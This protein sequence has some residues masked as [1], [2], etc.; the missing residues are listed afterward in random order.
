MNQRDIR[1][2]DIGMLRTFDALMREQNVS[3]AAARL[4]LSQP[5]VSASLNRLREVFGD[6]L[7]TRTSHG[8]VPTPRARA[9]APQVAK[10]LADLA[11]LL[12][13]DQ[14]FDPAR[15]QRIFR[16][17]GSDHASRMLLPALS[18]TLVALSS[19]IRIVW[20]PPGSWSLAEHLHKG[21][22]DLAV[23][24]RVQVPRDIETRVLYQDHYVYVM[25]QDHP[26]AAEP[27]TLD[28]FC[29]IPQIF[30][31]YGTSTLDDLIDETLARQGRQRLAQ[32]AVTSFGQIVH[33]LLHSDHAAV[34]G[35]RVARQFAAQLH[36]QPLPFEL[37]GYSS[38]LCWDARS[39]ADAGVQWL[40]GEILRTLATD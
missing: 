33:Q 25:R 15:S 18:Q 3:R 40:K 2:L 11:G 24:A 28:S 36:I 1:S 20:V 13:G 17:A 14:P 19:G 16:I 7:F 35:G 37:P 10:L 23:V 27:V 9:L 38:L 22:L 12:E 21:E 6:P 26:R 8:V 34:L 31:G 30:L 5:A 4:F 29:A 32:I 39:D